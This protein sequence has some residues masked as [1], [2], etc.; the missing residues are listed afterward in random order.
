M[1]AAGLIPRGERRA[2]LL[3]GGLVVLAV[4]FMVPGLLLRVSGASVSPPVAALA[5]GLAIVA[6]GFLLSWGAEAETHVGKGLVIA[7]LALITVLPEYSVDL[8]LAYQAGAQPD[9][10]YT[11]LAAANMTGANRLL[12]G[13]IWPLVMLLGWWRNGRRSIALTQDNLIEVL[14]LLG[15]SAYAFVIVVKARLDLVDFVVLLALFAA[16]L[17]RTSATPADEAPMGPSAVVSRLPRP[18]EHTIIAGLT[19]VAAVVIIAV[20]EPFV[21]ALIATGRQWKIS[22]FLLIQW[23]APLASESPVVVVTV[24]FVT[25]RK[26]TAALASL[27]S[28][29]I[30]QWT[31]LVGMLPVVYGIGAG[32]VAALPLDVRQREEFFLTAAQSLFGIGLLLGLALT[33]TG[34][35]ALAAMFLIQVGLAIAFRNAEAAIVQSL[36]MLAWVY[37]VGAL[38]LI[39]RRLQARRADLIQTASCQV[40]AVLGSVYYTE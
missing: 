17:W 6:A 20:T 27:I 16:Y 25:R 34:A 19:I 35:L 39:L 8:Y 23:I 32:R 7:V 11:S 40:P 26:E 29:K 5:F 13:L 12:V 36:T 24:L 21:E 2:L 14:F 38:W 3:F 37:L 1:R 15:A 22:E 18:V 10:A 9:T 30:N 4:A 31:L 33:P 28:D